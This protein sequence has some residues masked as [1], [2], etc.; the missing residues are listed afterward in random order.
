MWNELRLLKH[1]HIEPIFGFF[2]V[3]NGIMFT[4]AVHILHVLRNYL[5]A[6]MMSTD[7]TYIHHTNSKFHI[8][9]TKCCS[10]LYDDST[11]AKSRWHD[12]M[13]GFF[14]YPSIPF[15]VCR[16]CP[17]R[18]TRSASSSPRFASAKMQSGRTGLQK[19]GSWKLIS[20]SVYYI[21][22]DSF[23]FSYAII[24]YLCIYNIIAAT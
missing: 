6:L 23:I 20:T 17:R 1:W 24:S 14:R 15:P 7:L 19:R 13:L 11:M 10:K 3:C 12:S 18:T 4:C 22:I 5:C 9:C 8:I 21:Y 16:T 2:K